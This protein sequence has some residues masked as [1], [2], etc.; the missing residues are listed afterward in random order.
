M[1]GYGTCGWRT[2][3]SL[4][5]HSGRGAGAGEE[6]GGGER[7]AGE[8]MPPKLDYASPRRQPRA[9]CS[10]GWFV[11]IA[12]TAAVVINVVVAGVEVLIYGID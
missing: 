4:S 11:L 10:D 9:R 8:V 5:R 7:E 2:T 6:E 12:L 3:C 1:K